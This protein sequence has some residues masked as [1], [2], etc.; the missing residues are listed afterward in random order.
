M[1]ERGIEIPSVLIIDDSPVS[2]ASIAGCL[3]RDDFEIIEARDGPEGLRLAIEKRPEVILLDLNM[4][5][6]DGFETMRRLQDEEFT[7][8]IPVLLISSVDSPTIRAKGLDLGAAD[9]VVKSFA[10]EEMRARVRAALRAKSVRD[11][12]ESRA[13]LDALTGLGNRHALEERLRSDWVQAR[14][15]G[16][17]L[18]VLIADLDHFKLVND[19][20]GHQEGDRLL[21]TATRILREAVRGCDFVARY[22]G[23]EFLVIAQDCG[24]IGALAMGERFRSAMASA[25][26]KIHFG[27][28]S[29]GVALDEPSD[30][31]PAVIVGRADAALYRAKSNG[32]DSVWASH[33]GIL[34][35]AT[36]AGRGA[37]LGLSIVGSDGV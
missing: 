9:F 31:E 13:H 12:L 26:S 23:D 16:S 1:G 15:R 4:P 24:L 35:R 28:V 27:S 2:R 7:R 11:I 36:P 22:G 10:P 25:L 5:G 14:R 18:A 6:W 29:V 37:G 3:G 33:R 17:P 30:Q 19:R 34:R 20:H 32:R 21:Q 8:S